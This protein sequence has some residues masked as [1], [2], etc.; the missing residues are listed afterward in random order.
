MDNSSTCADTI[1]FL[2]DIDV[3]V[4]RNHNNGPW[5]DSFHNRHIYDALPNKF[6]LT[7][8]DLGF[9][10]DLPRDF[11]D[12]LSALSDTYQTAK[13]GFALDISDTDKMIPT[14]CHNGSTTYDCEIPFWSNRIPNDTYEIYEAAID[15][16]FHLC[17][18]Q[19]AD[20]GRHIRVAGSFTAKHLPWYIDNKVYTPYENYIASTNTGHYS[21]TSKFIASYLQQTYGFQ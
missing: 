6:V 19:F 2:K 3:Q 16:T 14:I 7:D 20:R 8:P 4:I 21:S 18:K 12:Q 1:Q 15:T 9:N 10:P 17:N 13:I 11:V 5:I